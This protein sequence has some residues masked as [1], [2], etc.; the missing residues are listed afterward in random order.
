MAYL[1]QGRAYVNLGKWPEALQSLR[2]AF[3]LVPEESNKAI[4][5]IIIDVFFKNASKLDH[6]TQSQIMDLLK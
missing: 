4:P 6:D 5:E 1:Y 3:R 2:T